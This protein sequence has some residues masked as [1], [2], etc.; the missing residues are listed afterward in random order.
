MT[1]N[2]YSISN[3][4]GKL[5]L[6]SPEPK[7]GYEQLTYGTE[8]KV[9]FHKYEDRTQGVLKYFDVKEVQYQGKTLSFLEVSLIDGDV[10][11]KVSVP[12]KNSKGNYT[13]EVKALVSSL[14]SADIGQNVTLSVTKTQ[15][16]AKNGK[17]YDNL[18]VYINYVDRL[19]DNGKGLS[20]GFISF[21][22]IPK[23]EKEEDEDLG[24]S[25]NWKPVNKFYAV[26]I[27]ELQ[28]KFQNGSESTP[29]QTPSKEVPKATPQQAFESAKPFK[30][31]A[32]NDLPF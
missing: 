6:K 25:W 11:N 7:E 9:T 20:T 12:L 19:G 27:K 28:A 29:T 24:V 18:N 30:A 13:D 32:H 3:S 21:D 15:S 4:K 10:S 2:N 5:Y 23:P 31:E 16:T 1:Y 22:E 14:N 26:K 8:N 17:V